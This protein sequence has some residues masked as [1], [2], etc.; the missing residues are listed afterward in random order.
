[1]VDLEMLEWD[2]NLISAPETRFLTPG[3]HMD[4]GKW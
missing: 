4:V 3:T 1:M 2:K